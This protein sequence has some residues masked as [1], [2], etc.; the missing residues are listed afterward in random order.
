[1]TDYIVAI[2]SYKRY[3]EITKK[4]LPTLI[5]GGVPKEVIHVFVANKTEE[6]LYREKLDPKTYG[7]IVVGEKGITN[8]RIF[9]NK[10][11][12]VGKRIV[13]LDDDVEQLQKLKGS[14]F[15]LP[16]NPKKK[17]I[18]KDKSKNKLIKINNVD[19]FFRDAFTLLKK[20]GLNLWGV[21]PTN[22]PFF[23]YNKITTDL[24]FIIGVCF[25][26]INHH[27][28]KLYPSKQLKG[29]SDY[30]QTILFYLKDKGVLRFN[31]VTT[32]TVFKAPGGMGPKRQKVYKHAQ[33]Y[34]VKKYPNIVKPKTRLDGTPE[35]RLIPNPEI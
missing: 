16:K 32:K 15:K 22:N 1:M 8:Q 4:T 35:V 30:H 34:L 26:F 13:S 24:R 17:T 23:M 27:D 31:N 14:N 11:F 21:Y 19:K 2:P 28:S 33:E 6:K 25:G 7:E 20:T 3:D 5:N 10:Y 18:N 12:P 9:I 29:K